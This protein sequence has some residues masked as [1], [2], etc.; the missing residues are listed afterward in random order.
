ITQI[1]VTPFG[2]RTYERCLRSILRQDPQVLM[3]GEIRDAAT[4]SIAVQAAL[5]G[6][7]LICTLHASTAA[8]AIARLIEMGVEPY[9]L[10]SSLHAVITQ[11]LVRRRV[12]S[13]YSGRI[14]VAAVATMSADS[15]QAILRRADRDELDQLFSQSSPSLQKF[16]RRLLEHGVT[17]EAELQRVG[18]S[19]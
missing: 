11:R 19:L 4:A 15:R 12:E 9:Q 16:A 17:D 14:P 13:G 6:H 10:T 7:R 3:L 8:G 18:L 2:E 1:E 5:S